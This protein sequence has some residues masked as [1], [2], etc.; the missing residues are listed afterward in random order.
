M[1]IVAGSMLLVA[2]V[3]LAPCARAQ[4]SG[5]DIGAKAPGAVVTT[6][7]GK[8]A[9]LAQYIGQK[10][11]LMEFWATWCPNCKELEPAMRAMNAKYGSKVSFVGV[12][13]S[14]N[15]TPALAKKYVDKH[16]LAWAQVYDTKG[17]ATEAYDVPATSYVVL[18][19]KTG[20][21]VYTGVGGNQDLEKA[22]K[23]VM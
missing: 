15:Q 5:I 14:V 1:K 12:A 8:S 22:I 3:L 18:V 21:V 13:V 19:D 2:T 23:K 6:L 11:V 9:N 7:D 10:P 16:K 20:K 17:S 4:D